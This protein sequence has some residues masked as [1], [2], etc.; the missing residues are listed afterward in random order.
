MSESVKRPYHAPR[1]AVRAEETRRR[2]LAAAREHFLA[3]GYAGTAV[4]DIARDAGVAEATVFAAFGSKRGLLLAVIGAAAGGDPAPVALIERPEWRAMLADPD[5]V[6]ALGRFAALTGA[7][8]A[9]AAPLI[10]VVRA[11]A[12]S[13]PELAE[14]LREGGASRWADCRTLAAALAARGQL[15]TGLSVETATDI[16]WAYSSAELY[17]LLVGVRG[18]TAE[19]YWEW[20]HAALVAALVADPA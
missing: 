15:H 13:E 4:A 11:A 17:E 8:L 10:A 19:D 2:I 18:W 12:G 14:M 20:R 6:S 3:A 5:P 7:T 1:R 9:R 16:L